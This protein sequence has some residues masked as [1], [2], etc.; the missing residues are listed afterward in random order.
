[1]MYHC[2]EQCPNETAQPV[3]RKLECG[4]VARGGE[5]ARGEPGVEGRPAALLPRGA[6]LFLVLLLSVPRSLHHI[7][8]RNLTTEDEHVVPTTLPLL[9]NDA[10]VEFPEMNVE[11]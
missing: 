3:H 7:S 9:S 6:L 10:V 5:R 4:W 8:S 1:M 2:F 11:V